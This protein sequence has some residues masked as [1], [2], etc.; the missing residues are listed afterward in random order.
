MYGTYTLK[1]LVNIGRTEETNSGWFG[2]APKCGQSVTKHRCCFW[3]PLLFR[4]LRNWRFVSEIYQ[5]LSESGPSSANTIKHPLNLSFRPHDHAF[6]GPTSTTERPRTFKVKA[7]LACT[8][9]YL[10]SFQL[11]QSN[12]KID[13]NWFCYAGRDRDELHLESADVWPLLNWPN[14]FLTSVGV[15]PRK[16]HADI[17]SPLATWTEIIEILGVGGV[18]LCLRSILWK[19]F[20]AICEVLSTACS[21]TGAPTHALCQLVGEKNYSEDIASEINAPKF[22]NIFFLVGSC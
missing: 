9:T 19:P 8:A 15:S 10:S 21:G 4:E 5:P 14:I 13:L 3:S 16:W 1:W 11:K 2:A 20:L 12:S 18:D 22:C 6:A 7:G 17:A